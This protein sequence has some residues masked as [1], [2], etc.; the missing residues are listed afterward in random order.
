MAGHGQGGLV[1]GHGSAG[2]LAP[3]MPQRYR[4]V[5]RDLVLTSRNTREQ[6]HP[7]GH[8]VYGMQGVRVQ[9]ISSTKDLA[10]GALLKVVVSGPRPADNQRQAPVPAASMLNVI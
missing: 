5:N 6:Q 7:R 9:P 1:L 4:A 2:A 10:E 8:T 3:G